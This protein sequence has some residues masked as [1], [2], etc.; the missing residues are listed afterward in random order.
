MCIIA[1][2]NNKIGSDIFDWKRE[3]KLSL[4]TTFMLTSFVAMYFIYPV[5]LEKIGVS[6]KYIG[7]IMSVFSVSTLVARPFGSFFIENL[8]IKKAVSLAFFFVFISCMGLLFAS[9]PFYLLL[10]R[11]IAGLGF[12]VGGVSLMA[13][14]SLIIPKG[15]RGGSF[16]WISVSYVLPQL[17]FLPVADFF[18][19][20]DKYIFYKLMF[21]VFGVLFFVF[22]VLLRE[23]NYKNL[24]LDSEVADVKWGSYKDLLKYRGIFTYCVACFV[25]AVV[26]GNILMYSSS[27]ASEK[28]LVASLFLSVNALV[29]LAVRIFGNKI[30]NRL[31]RFKWVGI[32]LLVMAVSKLFLSYASSNLYLVVCA[33]FYGVGMAISF[34]FLLAIASDL[35]PVNLRPKASTLTWFIMDVGWILGP[36]IVGHI[37]WCYSVAFAFKIVAILSIFPILW[38]EYSFKRLVKEGL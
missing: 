37:S 15:V 3:F 32:T 5:Y 6:A 20:S 27:L 31:N 38:I 4:L 23:I 36:V 29:A 18:I 25:F 24:I 33:L 2:S 17:V 26:N 34:P 14:Q 1:V 21:L 13:Y 8:G 16:A 35:V 22:G 19:S 11:F 30:L 10:F 9:K 7:F 12:G 28:G